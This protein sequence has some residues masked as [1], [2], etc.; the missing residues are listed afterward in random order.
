MEAAPFEAQFSTNGTERM[1]GQILQADA[2]S[3]SGIIL[4][5]DGNRY[6]FSEGDWR[7]AEAPASGIEV[8]FIPGE[9]VAREIFPLPS[10]P[11]TGP[12]P[13]NQSR[14]P[15]SEGSSVILG[16]IGIGLLLLGFIIPVL[17]TVAAFIIGLIG[18]DSAKRHNNETGLILSRIAWMGSLAL[19]IV[20][21]V[22]LA[23]AAAFAWPLLDLMFDH[24]RMIIREESV[25]TALAALIGA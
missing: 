18:A 1:R 25:R 17:P 6:S 5:S 24:L 7:G 22:L 14:S 9:G 12:S 20:G 11:T 13:T 15:A 19:M 8:D 3:G 16:V 10:P 23:L 4:G 2:A 21:A